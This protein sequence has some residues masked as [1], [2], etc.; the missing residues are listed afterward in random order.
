MEPGRWIDK[1]P[2][3]SGKGHDL[4]ETVRDPFVFAINGI[5]WRRRN[6]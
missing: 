4:G 6:F 5:L 3:N 2:E 1:D